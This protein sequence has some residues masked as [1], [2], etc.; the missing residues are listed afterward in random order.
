MVECCYELLC[1]IEEL[2]AQLWWLLVYNLCCT[3]ED[4]F[5]ALRASW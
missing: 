5:E 1:P 3:T 4:I 2:S